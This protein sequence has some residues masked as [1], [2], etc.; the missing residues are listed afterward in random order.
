M[1]GF[2]EVEIKLLDDQ[3]WSVITVYNVREDANKDE[4]DKFYKYVDEEVNKG[5]NV[6]ILGGLNGQVENQNGGIGRVLGKEGEETK[7]L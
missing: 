1:G 2:L 3:L 7:K 4:K 5:E 6:I